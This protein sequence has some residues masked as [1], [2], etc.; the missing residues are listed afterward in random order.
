[1]QKPMWQVR[2]RPCGKAEAAL[3]HRAY[4]AHYPGGEIRGEIWGGGMGEDCGIISPTWRR[5]GVVVHAHEKWVNEEK[6]R[7]SDKK[8]GKGR[9]WCLKR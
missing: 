5:E 4:T 9:K 6:G 2:P 7:K 8:S 3:L 1:M